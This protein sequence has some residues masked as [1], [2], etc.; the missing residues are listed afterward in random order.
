MR[1]QPVAARAVAEVLADV[2]TGARPLGDMPYLEVAGPREE[3]LAGA[4]MLLASRRGHPLKVEEVSD[5]GDPDRQRYEDGSLL[6]GAGA[7][8]AGP[9][10][11][12]WLDSGTEGT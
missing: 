6:P 11:E 5:P 2:A 4:A 10:F 12:E 3:T 7:V 8:L 9:T 1:T